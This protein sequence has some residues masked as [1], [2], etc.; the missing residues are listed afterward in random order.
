MKLQ[1]P[2][3]KHLVSIT[4][5]QNDCHVPRQGSKGLEVK[6][7][8]PFAE[9]V[10][11]SLRV[12]LKGPIFCLSCFAPEV[13]QDFGPFPRKPPQNSFWH[14]PSLFIVLRPGE[15][16]HT[17]TICPCSN[18]PPVCQWVWKWCPAL[19]HDAPVRF[20][21]SSVQQQDCKGA[22]QSTHTNLGDR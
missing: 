21:T 8:H 6:T 14:G 18:L 22:V 7:A 11:N 10:Q 12:P 5:P 3:S 1:D 4:Y 16:P 19:E 2:F 20:L 15:V 17:C 13:A 9:V